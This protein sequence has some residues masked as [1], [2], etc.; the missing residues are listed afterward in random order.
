MMAAL[1]GRGRNASLAA[2]ALALLAGVSLHAQHTGGRNG[3]PVAIAAKDPAAASALS[4]D[5]VAPADYVIGPEDQLS[6]VFFQNH[7]MSADVVV[8]SDGKI[9]LPL[10]NDVQASGRTPE[11]L[12]TAIDVDAKR[13][14][15]EPNATVTVKQINSRKV[16]I[17][18]AVEKPGTYALNAPTTVLQLIAMASGLKEYAD[19][20]RV[21]IVRSE[22]GRQASVTF[23]YKDAI[24]HRDMSQNIVLRPGDTVVVP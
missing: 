18:G 2:G 11:Q 19:S 6:I 17:V 23:N 14:M 21:L 5:V 8:R 1:A 20:R 4:A 13:F 10:I 22:P 12:R 15:Q 9:T 24:S 3:V 7:D 16:F